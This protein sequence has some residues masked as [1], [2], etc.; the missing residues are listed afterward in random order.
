M[1]VK[2]KAKMLEAV[3]A[4]EDDDDESIIEKHEDGKPEVLYAHDDKLAELVM[5]VMGMKG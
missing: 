3:N 1:P 5:V 4:S 2:M